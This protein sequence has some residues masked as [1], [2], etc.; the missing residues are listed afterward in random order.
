M[1]GIVGSVYNNGMNIIIAGFLGAIGSAM[2]AATRTI[3]A[4]IT[5]LTVATDMIDKPRAGRAF[6]AGGVPALRRSVRSVLA[7]LLLVGGPYLFLVTVFSGSILELV[8]GNKYAGLEVELR[9]WAL[10]M[11]LHMVAN[12]FST[13]LV[14]LKDTKSIFRANLTGALVAL[15]LAAPLMNSL[16]ITAALLGMS[17]GQFVNVALLY[18]ATRRSANNQPQTL[19]QPGE[20]DMVSAE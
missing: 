19:A 7:L 10:A 5:S 11:L 12:P 15:A 2:F 18:L 9:L 13:H 14:T 3:V 16:G 4:P 8:Y 6:V 1:S 17:G 20:R